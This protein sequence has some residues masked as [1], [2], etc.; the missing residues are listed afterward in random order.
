[1][2]RRT[3]PRLAPDRL[4]EVVREDDRSD[5][6]LVRLVVPRPGDDL[7]GP[8]VGDGPALELRVVAVEDDDVERPLVGV[9][10]QAGAPEPRRRLRGRLEPDEELQIDRRAALERDV[11]VRQTAGAL[12]RDQAPGIVVLD[13]RE[14][15]GE[16]GAGLEARVRD[17]VDLDQ[18]LELVPERTRPTDDRHCSS[19]LRALAQLAASASS[20]RVSCEKV[21]KMNSAGF[22]VARP[23]LP[24]SWPA[25]MTESGLSPLP[26]STENA[27][28]G[29]RERNAPFFIS[30]IMK[31]RTDRKQVARSES[32][33]FWC[34]AKSSPR[35]IDCSMKIT[36][37]R[38]ETYGK[39]PLAFSVRAPSMNRGLPVA[40]FRGLISFG[41]TSART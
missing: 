36:P 10:D 17:A 34:R 7:H 22:C 38:S 27:F 41:R 23:T 14:L 19:S 12:V 4:E 3:R 1:M 32:S 35:L 29:S 16:L 40:A 37:R 24:L 39:F 28:S 9:V 11:R 6:L 20:A 25:K 31:R 13:L 33:L 2:R 5:D 8:G 30:P 15:R 18:E 21:T 26:K